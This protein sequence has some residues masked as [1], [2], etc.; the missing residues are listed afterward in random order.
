MKP[1]TICII[2]ID[3]FLTVGLLLLMTY[4]L[5]GEAA[6]EW[7]GAGMF[8][9]CIMHHIL[10]WNWISHLLKGRYTAYR[11]S[12]TIVTA[13][14]FLSIV[15]LMIS[16]IILSRHVFDFLP[17][18]DGQSFA[19]TLHMLCAYWGFVLMSVHMGLHLNMLMGVMRKV[20]HISKPSMPR[21]IFLRTTGLLIAAYG[22]YAFFQ[23]QIGSYLFLQNQFVFFDFNE[24]LN[25]FFA[26][27][28]AIMGLFACIG[29]YVS[30]LLRPQ[31]QR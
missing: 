8:L 12:Q 20:I 25:A 24:P 10:N 16:G 30:K 27:Y 26:D 22:M 19:R 4:E 6:H 5:I 23:R 7:V 3:F 28:L 15:G 31:G 11:I 13:F 9:L 18:S 2:A 21:T 1:K 29:Y 17:I 14:V